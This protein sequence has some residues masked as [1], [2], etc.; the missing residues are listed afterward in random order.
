MVEEKDTRNK[1]TQGNSGKKSDEDKETQSPHPILPEKTTSLPSIEVQSKAFGI[2]EVKPNKDPHQDETPINGNG[3]GHDEQN[4]WGDPEIIKKDL[5]PVEPFSWAI[6]PEAFRDWTS[7]ISNRMQCP[8]DFLAMPDITLVGSLIGTRCGVKPKKFD[9][10]TVIPNLWGG[11]VGRPSTLKSPALAEAF[12]PLDRLEAE[13]K[14]NFD[15]KMD[16]YEIDL[17]E[18]AAR[19]EELKADMK[20]AAQ[21]KAGKIMDK[22]KKAFADLKEAEKP[23]WHRY[24][25]ND[26]TVEKIHELLKENPAGLL[27]SRDEIIAIFTS[28]EKPG[29][30]PDRAF[31]LE[32]WNGNGAHTSDRIGRGTTYTPNVCISLFGGIQPGKL[33]RYLYQAMG[34][35]DND[36]LIQRLQL[37]VYPDEIKNWKNVDQKPN[38]EAKERA[39]GVIKHIAK[40]DFMEYGAVKE[41]SDKFA[42]FHFSDQAQEL[43]NEWLAELQKKLINPD[44]HSWILEHLAKYR[45]LMPSLALIFHIIDVADG[46]PGG[47]ISLKAAERSAAA[48]EYLESHA[49]RIYGLGENTLQLSATQL[50]EKIKSGKLKD[51]FTV[52]DIYRN[53]WNSLNNKVLAQEACDELINAH[54]LKKEKIVGGFGRPANPSYL[55]NPNLK[56]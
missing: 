12:Q 30:E 45:S 31:F 14:E 35:L 55:I 28:W 3:A 41:D 54:W 52:R 34:S 49:R 56:L 46:A 4:E 48:C 7:D 18:Y 43:F 13:A 44:D 50:C 39:F 11:V 5:L 20:K 24:R 26:C 42:Y 15:E 53:N 33:T 6:I 16:S 25:T 8:P 51:G 9:D 40:M 27:L 38:Y 36:G 29:R 19:K 1:P 17:L 23:L 2:E 47:P 21:G 37:F 32:A 10:W 22:V